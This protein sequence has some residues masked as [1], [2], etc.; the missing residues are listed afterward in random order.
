MG[1]AT[2]ECLHVL[3]TLRHALLTWQSAG[4]LPE[5]ELP[6]LRH[7]IAVALDDAPVQL[8]FRLFFGRGAAT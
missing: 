1:G 6:L 8:P 2:L 4:L 7:M 3:S 5:T